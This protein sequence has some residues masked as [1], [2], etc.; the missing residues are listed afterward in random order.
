MMMRI[1]EAGGLAVDVETPQL[2]AVTT[3][4]FRNPYG[5]YECPGKIRRGEFTNCFKL[6]SPDRLAS[7]P[8]DYRFIFMA[9]SL[10][11][12]QN[13]WRAIAAE[14]NKMENAVFPIEERLAK[15][16]EQFL[17]WQK[18]KPAGALQ[19]NYDLV[20]ASPKYS[21]TCIAKF[22]NTDWEAFQVDAAA[23]AIDQTL[24]IRRE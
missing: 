13:S 2:D 19:L 5:L 17:L 23:K 15:S 12:I 16:S 3:T 20:C 6:L 10:T 7:V 14:Y 11:G 4:L 22:L 9:R 24:Y 21:A 1:L 18:V 8:A